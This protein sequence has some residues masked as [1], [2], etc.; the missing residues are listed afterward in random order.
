MHVLV[1]STLLYG[2][3]VWGHSLTHCGCAYIE[4]TLVNTLSRSIQAKRI[5]PHSIMLVEFDAYPMLA[6]AIFHVVMLLNRIHHMISTTPK[7]KRYPL[8][9]LKSSMQLASKGIC[10]Y[11]CSKT[12]FSTIHRPRYQAT[13]PLSTPKQDL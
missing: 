6:L 5:F 1:S 13:I 8:V 9:M 3:E 11:W 12:I 10:W 4:R 7:S 2:C